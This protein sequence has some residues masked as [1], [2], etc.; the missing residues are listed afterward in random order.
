V[1]AEWDALTSYVALNDR[2]KQ[3]LM[4][5]IRQKFSVI[6]GS[7]ARKMETGLQLASS[8]QTF[9]YSPGRR[10]MV[11]VSPDNKMNEDIED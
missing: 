9:E 8:L 2:E 3:S 6:K 4:Q 7:I 11:S 5:Q 10:R 1:A